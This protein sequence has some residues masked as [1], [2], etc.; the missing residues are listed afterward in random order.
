MT[1]IM[2][3][4]SKNYEPQ[5]P[6]YGDCI[7]IDT[8]TE[9]V[10]YDCG[11]EEHAKRVEEYMLTHNYTQAIGILSH[12]DSDHFKGFEYLVEKQLLSKMYAQLFLKHKTDIDK[13]L[14]DGRV[15]SKSLGDRIT[16]D[17]DNIA[18]LSGTVELVDAIELGEIVPG[19]EIVGPD[20]DYALSVVTKELDNRE[21]DTIDMETAYNAASVQVSVE[22]NE[23]TVLLCG[24]A[25]FESVKDKLNEYKVIQLP[26]H[27]KPDTAELIFNEKRFEY[28]T[29]YLISDNTGNT[30]GGSDKLNKVGKQIFNTLNGDITYPENSQGT[31]KVGRALGITGTGWSYR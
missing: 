1:K 27:G 25:S 24:D 13:R 15:T 12:N 21:G 19:I 20:K 17:Y 5:G 10:I 8:G 3:L 9:L 26:H 23:C 14:D 7:I 29:V 2:F 31:L 6:N 4:S 11:C 22:L 16:K 30:N 18:S 28:D